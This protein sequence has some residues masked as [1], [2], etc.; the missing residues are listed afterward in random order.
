M[1]KK[2]LALLVSAVALIVSA[3][4]LLRACDNDAVEADTE[5]ERA[6][7]SY[8]QS[9]NDTINGTHILTDGCRDAQQ[10]K[11]HLLEESIA[12]LFDGNFSEAA[13]KLTFLNIFSLNDCNDYLDTVTTP[14]AVFTDTL[15]N[16]EAEQYD[17]EGTELIPLAFS[18]EEMKTDNLE[19]NNT[20]LF[21]NHLYH[22]PLADKTWGDDYNWSSSVPSSGYNVFYMNADN[23]AKVI[24]KSQTNVIAKKYAW[25][26]FRGIPSE[27][28]AAYWIGSLA[29]PKDGFYQILNNKS[30]SDIRILIDKR[31]VV[32]YGGAST[33]KI[34]V[35][36]GNHT[37]EVE[38]RNGWHTTDV[39]VSITPMAEVKQPKDFSS[40][41]SSIKQKHPDVVALYAGVYEPEQQTVVLD[42][43][44]ISKPVVLYLSSYRAVEWQVHN[45][46]K[47]NIV[48]VIYGSYDKGTQVQGLPEEV[49]VVNGGIKNLGYSNNIVCHCGI[50]QCNDSIV[51]EKVAGSVSSSKL[52]EFYQQQ[53]IPVI[54]FV[55]DYSTDYFTFEAYNGDSGDCTIQ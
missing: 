12:E 50:S 36:T 37:V 44:L 42:I 43:S 25:S 49:T 54:Q 51:A 52:K 33:Q 32:D 39:S 29:V 11:M 38:Y 45:P 20:E 26:D 15:Y 41:L 1:H 23:L 22:F 14:S 34:F 19:V 21:D 24:E 31:I 10:T 9:A 40:F 13:K 17:D 48:G 55:G 53:D 5:R 2:N 27:K 28:F 35:P 3:L 30:H 46:Y 47:T 4:A 16:N 18:V 6:F 8:S 7:A